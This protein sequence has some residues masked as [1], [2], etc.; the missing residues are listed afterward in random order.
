M[1]EAEDG[2]AGRN[3]SGCPLVSQISNIDE[4]GDQDGGAGKGAGVL[5]GGDVCQVVQS[6]RH[7]EDALQLHK[8]R[9]ACQDPSLMPL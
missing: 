6:I 5:L 4:R 2:R 3:C 1:A 9:T 8:R 7:L